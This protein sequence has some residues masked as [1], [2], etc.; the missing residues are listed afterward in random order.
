MLNLMIK[1]LNYEACVDSKYDLILALNCFKEVSSFNLEGRE[2]QSL[3]PAEAKIIPKIVCSCFWHY[4]IHS[5]RTKIITEPAC[6]NVKHVRQIRGTEPI[7][8][9]KH[10]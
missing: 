2:F 1:N 8:Y 5:R 9:F 6:I 7:I 4:W 3:A 10:H